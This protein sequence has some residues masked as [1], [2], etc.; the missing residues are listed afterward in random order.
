MRPHL[1]AL[2]IACS[3]LDQ[4]EAFYSGMLELQGCGGAF[5]NY[6]V[7][8]GMYLTFYE[9][10]DAQPLYSG[11]AHQ[12]S[13]SQPG[14]AG[15]ALSIELPKEHFDRVVK[16]LFASSI[17]RAQDAPEWRGYRWGFTVKDPM[18]YTVELCTREKEEGSG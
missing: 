14:L 15:L 2:F 10:K 11:W 13:A 4:I 5:G 12:A 7:F 8:V 16:K 1:Q 9:R 3:S 18:G 17:P 6:D